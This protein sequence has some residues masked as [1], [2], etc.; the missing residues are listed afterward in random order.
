MYTVY[1]P[2]VH[3]LTVCYGVEKTVGERGFNPPAIQ[4]LVTSDAISLIGLK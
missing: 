1:N 4:T 3:N 2:P